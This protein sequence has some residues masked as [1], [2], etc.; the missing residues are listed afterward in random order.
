MLGSASINR[1]TSLTQ[2]ITTVQIP[3]P[4][5]AAQLHLRYRKIEAPLL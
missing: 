1:H 5:A 4:D 3:C 2:A